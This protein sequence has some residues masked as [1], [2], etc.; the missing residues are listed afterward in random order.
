VEDVSTHALA[1]C[2]AQ[3]DVQTQSRNAHA[4]V[5]LILRDQVGIVVVMVV[6]AE[7]VGMSSMPALLLVRHDANNGGRSGGS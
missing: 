4:S 1:Q 2:H 3:V 5:L 6:M 7:A